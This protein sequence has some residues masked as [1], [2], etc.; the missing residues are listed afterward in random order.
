MVGQLPV[1]LLFTGPDPASQP[2][3]VSIQLQPDGLLQCDPKG[4][5]LLLD[6]CDFRH[7]Y[8]QVVSSLA[9]CSADWGT[10]DKAIQAHTYLLIGHR[11]RYSGVKSMLCFFPQGTLKYIIELLNFC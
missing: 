6:S 10:E 8:L 11:F 1:F 5:V 2:G 9:N 3:S 7:S 4:H